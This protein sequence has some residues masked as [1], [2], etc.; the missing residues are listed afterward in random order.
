MKNLYSPKFS[1]LIILF[2]CSLQIFAQ[3]PV[4][5]SFSP[6]SGP[7]GTI[8]HISGQNFKLDIFPKTNNTPNPL[9]PAPTLHK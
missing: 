9:R 6:P 3:T 8:A 4:I 7:V 5:D 2:I 1:I